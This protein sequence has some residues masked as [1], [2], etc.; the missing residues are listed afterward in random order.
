MIVVF[1]FI[2]FKDFIYLFLDRGERRE[3]GEKHQCV[4]ATHAPPTGDLACSPG[5]C[6]DWELNQ[7]PFGS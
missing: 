2:L 5:M 7:R 1:I 3:K 4:V 6:P